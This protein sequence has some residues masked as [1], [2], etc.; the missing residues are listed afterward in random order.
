MI[1]EWVHIRSWHIASGVIS[2]GGMV[3]TMCGR[4]AAKDAKTE[5]NLPTL[6]KTCESCFRLQEQRESERS[7]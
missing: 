3:H 6:G 7:R 5:V 1:N 4:W 2:R